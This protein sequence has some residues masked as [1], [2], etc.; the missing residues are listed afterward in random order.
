MNIPFCLP[1]IDKAVGDEM[2]DTLFNTGW[3]TTGPKVKAFEA[4]IKKLTQAKSVL[5]VNSWNSGTT[6]MMN[7]WGIKA[8]DEVIIPA[9][10]YAATAITV[11]NMG[12]IPIMV[13]VASDF[14]I[15]VDN[16]RKAITSK[17]K[18]IIPVDLG[19]NPCDLQILKS[20]K[21]WVEF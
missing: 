18:I 2:H 12:A 6:V 7:W 1:L 21:H 19:G 10:T 14:N 3:L 20:R 4:E 17:T 11:M 13:D 9:Y 5:C 15:T 16:I 8:G